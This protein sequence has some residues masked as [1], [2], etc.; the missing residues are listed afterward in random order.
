M[1]PGIWL[2]IITPFRRDRVDVDALPYLADMYPR[3]EISGFVALGT[4]GEAALLSRT[5]RVSVLNALSMSSAKDCRC[6]WAPTLRRLPRFR[7]VLRLPR[8]SGRAMAFRS[9]G[10]GD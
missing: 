4:T 2:P 10:A 9:G 3:T 5:E 1:D 8:S 7:A 6:S